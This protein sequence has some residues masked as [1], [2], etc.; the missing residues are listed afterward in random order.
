MRNPARRQLSLKE[1][2]KINKNI[3]VVILTA[4][5]NMESMQEAGELTVSAFIPKLS[6]YSDAQVTL[7]AA[8]DLALKAQDKEG[9]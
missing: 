3:P 2:R 5:P 8:L 1:I 4:H 9:E 7:K 6:I